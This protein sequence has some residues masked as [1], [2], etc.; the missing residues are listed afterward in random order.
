MEKPREFQPHRH[1]FEASITGADLDCEGDKH[2]DSHGGYLAMADSSGATHAVGCE[3]GAAGCDSDFEAEE[4]LSQPADEAEESGHGAA[5]VRPE[6][7]AEL[8][9]QRSMLLDAVLESTACRWGRGK[10]RRRAACRWSMLHPSRSRHHAT[11]RH[12][13]AT[14][15]VH[16]HQPCRASHAG[17]VLHF[18]CHVMSCHVRHQAAPAMMAP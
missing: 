10:R 6:L 11:C 14:A 7:I 12:Q 9:E 8:F 16:E 15:H 4:Q 3:D 13:A 18:P 5:G 2:S 17:R 1:D